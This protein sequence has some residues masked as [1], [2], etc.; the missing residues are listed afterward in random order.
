MATKHIMQFESYLRLTPQEATYYVTLQKHLIWMVLLKSFLLS[1]HLAS[2]TCL[3]SRTQLHQKKQ[4][5][6][7]NGDVKG[8]V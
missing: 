8:C 2:V 3:V 1:S 5:G 4:Y 6:L 7:C